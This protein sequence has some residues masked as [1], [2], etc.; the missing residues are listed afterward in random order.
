MITETSDLT[1]A[2][3][4]PLKRRCYRGRPEAVQAPGPGCRAPRRTGRDQS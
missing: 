3:R 1:P 2:L 4:P